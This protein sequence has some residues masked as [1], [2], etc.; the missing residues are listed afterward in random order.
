MGLRKATRGE[1]CAGFR[2]KSVAKLMAAARHNPQRRDKMR[3]AICLAA[4]ARL[5]VPGG[6]EYGYFA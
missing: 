2:K 6:D 3:L 1:V 5:S 4:L